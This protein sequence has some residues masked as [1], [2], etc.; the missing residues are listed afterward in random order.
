M[1]DFQISYQRCSLPAPLSFSLSVFRTREP[2]P[3]QRSTPTTRNTT[4]GTPIST[5][6]LGVRRASANGTSVSW[7]TIR[8]RPRLKV[9]TLTN[10]PRPAVAPGPSTRSMGE[11][12]TFQRSALAKDYYY[13]EGDPDSDDELTAS[14]FLAGKADGATATRAV[15][16][17]RR[18]RG[19]ITTPMRR[20]CVRCAHLNRASAGLTQSFFTC[21]LSYG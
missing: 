21:Q 18:F 19:A 14:D 10:Q 4:E 8:E 3:A 6:D 1:F 16:L 9:G 20:R 7:P 5:R 2:Y 13:V 12:F 17:I 11:P 15:P